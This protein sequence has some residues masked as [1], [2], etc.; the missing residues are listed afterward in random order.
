[1]RNTI[2]TKHYLQ[3][4]KLSHMMSD[5]KLQPDTALSARQS[6]HTT[7][8]LGLVALAALLT[9]LVLL[10]HDPEFEK[11]TYIIA[12]FTLCVALLVVY[13]LEALWL[14]E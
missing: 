1:M 12:K 14:Y 13:A 7:T 4:S 9:T 3:T 2:S 8:Q 10:T 5:R 6:R 11:P